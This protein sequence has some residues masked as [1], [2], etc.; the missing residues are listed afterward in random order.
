MIDTSRGSH[1]RLHRA[2]ME[3]GGLFGFLFLAVSFFDWL[4]D[5]LALG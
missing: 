4:Q 2:L 3:I 5:S 1:N